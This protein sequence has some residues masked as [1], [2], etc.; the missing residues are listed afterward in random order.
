M[1]ILVHI[2]RLFQSIGKCDLK[3]GENYKNIMLIIISTSDG[4]V[5]SVQNVKIMWQRIIHIFVWLN[6]IT[7]NAEKEVY[8][9]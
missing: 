1:N 2:F 5:T 8:K 3:S 6:L 7:V 4:R 9:K